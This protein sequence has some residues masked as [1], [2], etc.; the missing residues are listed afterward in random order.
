MAVPTGEQGLTA[1]LVYIGKGLPADYGQADV[2][3]KIVLMDGLAVP[4]AVKTA[5]EHGAAGALFIN[6]KYTHE[7]IVSPVWGNPTPETVNLL[8]KIPV[9]SVNHADGQLIKSSF[10]NGAK[11]SAF[12]QT[13]V[14]TG[15]RKIPTLVAEIKGSL[16]PD[17]FVMFSGHI[18]SW[19]YGVMDNGT[20]NATMME[21]GRILSKHRDKLRR[22]L[23]LAFWSGHSH[24]RYAGSA[25]YCDTHW[26]DLYENCVMHINVDS[27]G[28]Q[29]NDVL[30]E[31]SSMVEMVDLGAGPIAAIANQQFTGSRFSRAGDQ[32]FLGTGTPSLFMGLSE[33]EPSQE[34]ASQAFSLLFGGGRAG[35]FG[36]WWHTTEDT[37]DKI[38]PANLVRDCKIYVSTVYQACSNAVLPINQA[39]AVQEIKGYLT[40]YQQ[41]AGE[42]LDL[43]KAI[44][45]LTD[46]DT[47]VSRAQALIQNASFSETQISMINERLMELS[48]LLVPLN[49]VR[50]SIFD[51]DLALK[52]VPIPA[53]AEIDQLSRSEIGSD[54]YYQL[55]TLLGRRLNQ[56]NYTL[57]EANREAEQLLEIIT[58]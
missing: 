2:Q 14:D 44:M 9:V 3:G 30:T 27:V 39:A 7:M 26:E 35:G 45:R 8:P 46:L 47:K 5:G 20:A 29:G 50:G 55:R 49:Y 36:W 21:V 12:I 51:H 18:D 11:V 54:S 53:L 17:T 25:W 57:L 52:A 15:W 37:I 33:R 48:R 32:S 41:Q 16:E 22:T 31:G 19:H 24:G 10:E 1:E 4:R 42:R 6:A 58:E 23:R 38:D 34:P 56:I 43:S 13:E 28:G 40:T